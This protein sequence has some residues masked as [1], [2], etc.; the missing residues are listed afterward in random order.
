MSRH[1]RYV[2]S[3]SIATKKL[4]KL[5][6]KQ[7]KISRRGKPSKSNILWFIP[8]ARNFNLFSSWMKKVDFV[9]K[10]IVKNHVHHEAIEIGINY[11]NEHTEYTHLLVSSDD[12][13][14]VPG[15]IKL[16]IKDVSTYD[17]PVVTGWCNTAHKE[18]YANITLRRVTVVDENLKRTTTQFKAAKVYPYISIIDVV[19]GKYGY[20]FIK[21]WYVGFPLVLIKRET[22]AKIPF[23]PFLR[24]KDRLCITP[25]TKAKG[26]GTGY[27]LQFCIDCAKN[28]VPVIVDTRVFLLHFGKTK[29]HVRIG[30]KIEGINFVKAKKPSRIKMSKNPKKFAAS[31]IMIRPLQTRKI[32][33]RWANFIA[34]NRKRGI[35]WY[36]GLPYKWWWGLNSKRFLEN[37]PQHL[38]K[39]EPLWFSR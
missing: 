34:K 29:S 17:F 35:P 27:D 6:A 24:Q 26:R 19:S 12:V 15:Y 10:L 21:A 33:E 31:P 3:A 20:P 5:Y 13:L 4:V 1:R 7:V 11:F 38:N 25:E 22:L 2:T 30:P 9:D 39:N 32:C 16:L 28:N 8:S 36:H 37:L 14:G 18:H 23:R